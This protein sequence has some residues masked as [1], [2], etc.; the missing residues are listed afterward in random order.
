[1]GASTEEKPG[2]LDQW[3]RQSPRNHPVQYEML[4]MH[5]DATHAMCCTWTPTHS[6]PEGKEDSWESRAAHRQVCWNLARLRPLTSAPPGLVCLPE[7][8]T[9][10]SL[11]ASLLGNESPSSIHAQQLG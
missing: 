5:C 1:M 11:F 8:L 4:V 6:S 7:A 10:P 3:P 9:F 2:G